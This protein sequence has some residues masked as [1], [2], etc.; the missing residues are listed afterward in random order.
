MLTRSVFAFAFLS[1]TCAG[2]S[3]D[4]A[5]LDV[6]RYCQ[7]LTSCMAQE[8]GE[9]VQTLEECVQITEQVRERAA[10]DGCETELAEALTCVTEPLEECSEPIAQAVSVCV[11]QTNEYNECLQ[12]EG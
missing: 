8:A 1:L 11:D 6:D 7:A 3:D 9:Q 12:P 2:C 4:P 5:E 10:S